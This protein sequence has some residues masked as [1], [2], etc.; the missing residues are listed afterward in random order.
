MIHCV[1]SA[2][3]LSERHLISA[4]SSQSTSSR[5][6]IIITTPYLIPYVGIFILL[7]AWGLFYSTFVKCFT[8]CMNA[9]SDE[10]SKIYR[11]KLNSYFYSALN[12]YQLN[13][14]KMSLDL[15]RHNTIEHNKTINASNNIKD[16]CERSLSRIRQ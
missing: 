1:A 15:Q 14:L 10:R 13:K 2:F 8:Y 3:I 16:I 11:S 7:A 6:G 5:F 4:G 9:L 12:S